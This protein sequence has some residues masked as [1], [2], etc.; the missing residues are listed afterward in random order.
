[1]KYYTS[2][3]EKNLKSVVKLAQAASKLGVLIGG[4][5]VVW[6]SLRIGYFPQDL[7][8]RHNCSMSAGSAGSAAERSFASVAASCR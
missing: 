7:T 2:L 1:M 3:F 4:I 8:I 5:C 6:Y